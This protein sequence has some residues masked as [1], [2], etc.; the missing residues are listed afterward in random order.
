MEDVVQKLDEF[1]LQLP[2]WKWRCYIIFFGSKNI[3]NPGTNDPRMLSALE[4][5]KSNGGKIVAIN[6]LKEAG[7]VRFKNPIFSL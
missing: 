7:L 1:Q 4:K 5:C 3:Q 6:P 2:F